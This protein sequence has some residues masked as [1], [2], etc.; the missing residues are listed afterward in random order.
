MA[1]VSRAGPL[2]WADE[3]S[4]G[5]LLFFC[6]PVEKQFTTPQTLKGFYD[7][8]MILWCVNLLNT[9][10]FICPLQ[11]EKE[12]IRLAVLLQSLLRDFSIMKETQ[13]R[14]AGFLACARSFQSGLKDTWSVMN[15]LSLS[16]EPLF[17]LIEMWQNVTYAHRP[18]CQPIFRTRASHVARWMT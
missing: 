18:F 9:H 13:I 11:V 17:A 5:G 10:V 3:W 1:F 4:R 6:W 8:L 7:D 14:L 16:H 12:L 15:L 2:L